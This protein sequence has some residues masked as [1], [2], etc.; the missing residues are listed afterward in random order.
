[1]L[2]CELKW[3]VPRTNLSCQSVQIT[4][5]W[6]DEFQMVLGCYFCSVSGMCIGGGETG[7]YVNADARHPPHTCDSWM[8]HTDSAG[9]S[10]PSSHTL[11][12]SSSPLHCVQVP[13]WLAT[14][15]HMPPADR[16]ANYTIWQQKVSFTIYL[17][18]LF[19]QGT[20]VLLFHH[21]IG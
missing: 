21:A 15:P 20:S 17:L 4:S 16:C 3:A 9:R 12:H 7:G 19:L 8:I 5:W 1:M 18:N 11:Y 2:M 10:F 6:G 13:G 14:C